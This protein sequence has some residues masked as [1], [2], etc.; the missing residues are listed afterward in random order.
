MPAWTGFFTV[1]RCRIK[2]QVNISLHRYAVFATNFPFK[3]NASGVSWAASRQLFAHDQTI[4]R[5]REHA[6]Q[7][8]K[9]DAVIVYRCILRRG[10]GNLVAVRI[11]LANSDFFFDPRR[12][13]DESMGLS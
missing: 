4:A 1:S 11:V 6:G 7:K 10:A 3:R 9:I 13:P 8:D 12:V 5:E 2:S